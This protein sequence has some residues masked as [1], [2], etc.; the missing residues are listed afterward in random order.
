[1][2]KVAAKNLRYERKFIYETGTPEDLIH[3]VVLSNSFCFREI[4]HRRTVNN[5][6][7]DDASMSFYHQ[8][9][10][11]DEIRDKYR[12]RWYG[13]AF[14]I[15][16]NPVLEIKKKYGAVGD[17]L[18]FALSENTFNLKEDSTKEIQQKIT[19][20]IQEAHPQELALKLGSLTP[21]LYNSYE[22]RYF[23]SNCKRY[24][25]TIDY[26]M[27][28][29]NPHFTNYEVSKAQL[30]DVVLELKYEVPHDKES[31]QL[32]Q[33]LTSRLSKN[34]KYVRGVHLIHHQQNN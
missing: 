1:M 29:Y 27:T 10:S 12:L 2:G 16:E 9:V 25:I 28:F 5:I 20:A 19:K 4:F 32:T 14:E 24:R 21:S 33:Q 6:Y 18:S 34:S 23:L 3:T 7:Y 17:K 11:G 13:D 31:R 22:R 26:N 15:I 8:N 30:S